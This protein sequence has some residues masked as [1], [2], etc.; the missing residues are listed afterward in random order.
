[1]FLAAGQAR[2]DLAND[3]VAHLDNAR[4]SRLVVIEGHAWVTREGEAADE[5]L[6]PGEGWIVDTDEGVTVSAF[7]GAA[8]LGVS[9]PPVIDRD[10]ALVLRATRRSENLAR[11]W[12]GW[13]TRVS[14]S[15]DSVA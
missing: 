11:R 15:P 4:G 12:R 2:L 1:M 7:R 6:G 5:V 3:E 10:A 8:S 14:L 9:L 13:M